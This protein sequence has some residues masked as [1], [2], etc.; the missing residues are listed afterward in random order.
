[1]ACHSVGNP[2]SRSRGSS[3][4]GFFLRYMGDV[5]SAEMT[6]DGGKSNNET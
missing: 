3:S 2:L 5:G 6:Y 4:L 1:M